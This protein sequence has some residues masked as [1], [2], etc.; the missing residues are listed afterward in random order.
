MSISV[1]CQLGMTH[2]WVCSGRNSGFLFR[3]QSREQGG[4][5]TRSRAYGHDWIYRLLVYVDI[6]KIHRIHV[7]VNF[8]DLYVRAALHV[9]VN[10]RVIHIKICLYTLICIHKDI[11]QIYVYT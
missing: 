6:W 4:F 2:L 10:M 5:Y 1:I 7:Y 3:T 8:T 9:H 11:L